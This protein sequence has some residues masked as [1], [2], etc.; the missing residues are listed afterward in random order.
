MTSLAAGSQRVSEGLSTLVTSFYESAGEFY[1][2]GG[3]SF[4]GALDGHT[5]G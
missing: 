2:H 4:R 1:S 5:P 3:P